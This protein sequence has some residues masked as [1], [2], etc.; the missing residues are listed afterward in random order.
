V[1]VEGSRAQRVSARGIRPRGTAFYEAEAYSEGV[2]RARY[3]E[4]AF[5][6]AALQG[7]V[8]RDDAGMLLILP[9]APLDAGAYEAAFR[10]KVAR[11]TVSD[12]VAVLSVVGEGGHT[13][14]VR[15]P[16]Y[17]QD[18]EDRLAYHHFAVRFV[19][20]E[21]E[22]VEYRVIFRGVVDVWVDGVLVRRLSEVG[23]E[24]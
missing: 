10:L 13:T 2:G 15:R 23:G 8:R 18:F 4:D 7:S 20:Q 14:L 22:R 17:G 5:N 21:G 9:S 16:L 3:D 1:V 6:G 12:E 24:R 19:A 11:Q